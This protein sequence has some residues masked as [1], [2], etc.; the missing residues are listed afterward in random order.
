MARLY[1]PGRMAR[2]YEQAIA[3][4]PGLVPQRVA[5]GSTHSYVHWVFRAGPAPRRS[6]LSSHLARLG[7]ETKAY[8]RALHLAWEQEPRVHLPVTESLDPEVLALPMSSELTDDA[9][10]SVAVALRSSVAALSDDSREEAGSTADV[11]G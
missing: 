5:P 11:T 6:F 3:D 7:V 4:L 8:F 1:E 2:L 9:A 10:E